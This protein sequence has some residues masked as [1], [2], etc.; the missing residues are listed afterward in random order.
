MIKYCKVVNKSKV[1][2]WLQVSDSSKEAIHFYEGNGF[3]Y[4]GKK[5]KDMNKNL[6][7]H[8]KK[9]N[10]ID[11]DNM[12]LMKCSDGYFNSEEIQWTEEMLVPDTVPL[13]LSDEISKKIGYIDMK[14]KK[15]KEILN[16]IISYE[17]TFDW[18]N[19]AK[20]IKRN[21]SNEIE[22]KNGYYARREYDKMAYITYPP[23]V[24]CIANKGSLG[25]D[26]IKRL[27]SSYPLLSEYMK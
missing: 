8:L 5:K 11:Q 10:W 3:T 23:L 21:K 14:N 7:E 9:Y 12:Q 15:R 17:P 13:E 2:I 22:N 25:I 18:R 19:Y 24:E 4:S 1:D 16:E 27:I 6:R 20:S 26:T